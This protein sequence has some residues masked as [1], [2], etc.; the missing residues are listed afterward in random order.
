MRVSI[1]DW[2]RRLRAQLAELPLDLRV[3]VER[4]LAAPHPALVSGL[5]ELADLVPE[6]VVAGDRRAGHQGS[7]LGLHVEWRLA[8]RL[9]PRRLRLHELADLLGRLGARCRAVRSGARPL[10]AVERE[11]ALAHLVV[12]PPAPDRRHEGAG[13]PEERDDDHQHCQTAVHLAYSVPHVA[14]TAPADAR[15]E[16]PGALSGSDRA[17]TPVADSARGRHLLRRARRLR[18]RSGTSGPDT[19]SSGSHAFTFAPSL[20]ERDDARR[21][22]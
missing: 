5:H 4:L 7:H 9:A 8:P 13:D 12:E 21:G 10:V 16:P 11:G 2:S 19:G 14:P 3:H 22:G 6:S 20:R 15:T 18:L 1:P 17:R